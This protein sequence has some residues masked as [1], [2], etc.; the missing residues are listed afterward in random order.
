MDLLHPRGSTVSRRSTP[1]KPLTAGVEGIVVLKAT[2]GPTGEV[3]DVEVL[4]SV[5]LL[6]EAA[7]AAVREWRYEPML[8]DGNPVRVRMTVSVDFTLSRTLRS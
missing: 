7:M 5:P 2:I 8:V 6:D 4:H 1:P 3:M